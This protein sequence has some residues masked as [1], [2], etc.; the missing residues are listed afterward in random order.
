LYSKFFV[1]QKCIK[2]GLAVV[3][4]EYLEVEKFMP[5]PSIRIAVCRLLTDEDISF[6]F[7]VLEEISTKF[8]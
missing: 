4:S 3:V 1:F 6:A 8:Y 7:K 2:N 5:Q